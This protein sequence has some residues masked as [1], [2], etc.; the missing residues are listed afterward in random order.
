MRAE[1][2]RMWLR[3]A[4]R[5]E[6]PKPGNWE[7][8][9]TIIQATFRGGETVA[10]CAWQTLVTIHKG[11]G[12]DSRRIGLVEVLW[13]SI[14]GIINRRILSSIQFHDSL[15]GFIAGR[16]TGKSTLEAK[17]LHHLIYMRETVLH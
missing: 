9:V 15:H 3:V 5:E 17:I 6:N 8:V 13:K 4:T 16:E 10:S 1:H 7:K 12:T 2:L 14:S 11:V